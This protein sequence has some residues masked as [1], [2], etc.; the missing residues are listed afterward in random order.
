[1]RERVIGVQGF[2]SETE[3]LLDN[4]VGMSSR[5]THLTTVPAAMVISDGV[6]GKLSML[7]SA[8]ESS[9]GDVCACPATYIEFDGR[10]WRPTT[11]RSKM[12]AVSHEAEVTTFA[13]RREVFQGRDHGRKRFMAMGAHVA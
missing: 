2:R 6:N 8:I 3:Q 13:L 4:G 11:R 7:I 12:S 9:R 10:T 5:F 1:M